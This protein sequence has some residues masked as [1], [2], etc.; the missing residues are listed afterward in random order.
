MA[1][2]RPPARR[3]RMPSRGQ[4]PPPRVRQPVAA[5]RKLSADPLTPREPTPVRPGLAHQLTVFQAA[6]P[7][8]RGEANL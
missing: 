6:L 8:S 1:G 4:P 5:T 3:Q 2:R 7:G